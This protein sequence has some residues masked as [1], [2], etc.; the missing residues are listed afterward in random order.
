LRT[1][2]LIASADLSR[3]LSMPPVTSSCPALATRID[4]Q[5]EDAEFA[6]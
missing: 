4:R 5:I 2:L 1:T 3:P 6:A